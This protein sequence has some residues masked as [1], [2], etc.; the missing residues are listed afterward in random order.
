MNISYNQN[1]KHGDNI[2]NFSSKPREL[3]SGLQ[4]Q[5]IKIITTGSRVE[6][7]SVLGDREAYDFAFQIKSFLEKKGYKVDGVNQSVFTSSVRGQII[8]SSKEGDNSF[9]IIIGNQE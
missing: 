1:N 8:E 2:M 3:D 9:R 7:F 4:E 6:V 5:L